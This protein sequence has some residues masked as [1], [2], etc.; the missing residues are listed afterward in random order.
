MEKQKRMKKKEKKF[1]IYKII[2]TLLAGLA[3][4][5][6][7]NIAP[8][9]IRDEIA[10]KTNLVINNSNVTKVLKND[11]IIDNN[12]IYISTKDIANF[13]DGDIFYDNKYD[14]IITSSDTKLATLKIDEKKVSINGSDISLIASAIKKDN[15]FYLPISE[16]GKSVYNVETRYIKDTNIVVIVSLD[17]ELTYVNSNK[18]NNIKSKPTVFS[19]TIDKVNSGDNITLVN[20][21][22]NLPNGWSKV[23]T[24]NGKIGYVKTNTLVNT[25]K[26]RE[27]LEV[28]N[29][30]EGKIS[31]VWDYF[32]QYVTA[33]RRSGEI[34]GVNVVSPTFFY[35]Q[36]LGKGNILANV[37]INGENYIKWAHNNGYK[38]WALVSNDSMKETTSEILN[39]YKL[40]ENLINNIVTAVETYNLD[41]INLDFENI[42]MADKDMFTRLVIELAPRLRELGKILSVDVTAPDGSEDWSLC[43]DRNEI[44][45]NADYIVFM[46]Y[47]QYGTS[48]TSA[49]TTAGCNWVEANI[50]KFLG[51]EE[52]EKDK[53][54]LG[55]PFYT[56]TWTESNGKVESRVVDMESIADILPNDA[57]IIWDEELKQNYAEYTRN[58][59]QYKMWIEDI[60]SL[61]A[62]LELV[63][64]YDLAGAAY[65]EKDRETEDIWSLVAQMLEVE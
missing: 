13:F 51:Q 65:W 4:L 47:D 26:V 58:D 63:K 52:V 43:Y 28:N 8:N 15:E 55:M 29:K 17:R 62:K 40:R 5:F 14:Q 49:G 24:Q 20:S 36:R 27:N 34:E 31:M 1:Y 59:I 45:E 33:P 39:D 41:G 9:Y 64:T 2:A 46:G 42:Y 60:D 22:E 23:T 56:R 61:K 35:L 21:T 53:I 32:S 54:I 18:N 7:L 48:S 50:R 30:I 11:V 12:I 57:T 19:K 44:A 6:V 25:T 16:I 38:V 10:D 37:G 3:V